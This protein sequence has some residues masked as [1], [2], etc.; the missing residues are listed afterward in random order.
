MPVN[1]LSLQPQLP[2]ADAGASA[3]KRELE[4]ETG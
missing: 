2:P 3:P 1:P 4:E